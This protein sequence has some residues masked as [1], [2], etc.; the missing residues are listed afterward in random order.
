M[1]KGKTS[2]T[3]QVKL[4]FDEMTSSETLF[5][6]ILQFPVFYEKVDSLPSV[7]N[8]KMYFKRDE[9]GLLRLYQLDSSGS[10]IPIGGESFIWKDPV[11]DCDLSTPPQQITIG[12]RYRV[13]PIGYGE[14]S[15]LDNHLVTYTNEGW[16]SDGVPEERWSVLE[17]DSNKTWIYTQN[18]WKPFAVTSVY[19]A[20][21]GLELHGNTFQVAIGGITNNMLAGG[22]S[23]NKLNNITTPN[24]VEWQAV[25]KVNSKLDDL[26][27]VN[28]IN[29]Q[30]REFL[31][32]DGINWTNIK[33]QT[34]DNIT[35]VIVE[36]PLYITPTYVEW[37]NMPEA[38][39]EMF[40]SGN[41]Y[42][43]TVVNVKY[44]KKFRMVV[45][46][47]SASYQGAPNARIGARWAVSPS[48]VRP[49]AEGDSH[50]P[51]SA[52]IGTGDYP[53]IWDLAR[54]GEWAD[55]SQEARSY[56]NIVL[57]GVGWGGNGVADPRFRSVRVQFW[58]DQYISPYQIKDI[59]WGEIKGTL[60]NQTDLKNALDM[61]AD[62]D[63]DNMFTSGQTINE[64]L[65]LLPVE[66]KADVYIGNTKVLTFR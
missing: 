48:I 21:E 26:A 18:E 44:F 19:Q 5:S 9:K 6:P 64:Y 23:D 47:A 16:V 20:G 33:L 63:K 50:L 14:W 40:G 57:L 60:A 17:L 61:K 4:L 39:T 59:F 38:L 34:Q 51:G 62:I 24:K 66:G 56:D 52:H 32:Y 2:L 22:I 27:D 41:Q 43:R 65:R 15:G 11:L 45:Y 55:I 42:H 3:K 28:L 30:Q 36:V 29:V 7:N 8:V 31:M 12:D 25:N 13:K 54:Y 49:L 58:T 35:S 46:L 53:P 37:T 1:Q 10:E